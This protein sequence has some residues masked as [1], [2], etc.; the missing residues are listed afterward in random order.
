MEQGIVSESFFS[1][2]INGLKNP[3]YLI[4]I[5]KPDK[6]LLRTLLG[7]ALDG[8]GHLLLFRIHKTDH[9]GKGFEGRKPM[10]ACFDKAIS[11]IMQILKERDN[12]F[13]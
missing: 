10:I 11:F 1:L 9:F 4:L 13:S 3:E 2:Q 7:N 8:I 12:E 5:Q 6:G